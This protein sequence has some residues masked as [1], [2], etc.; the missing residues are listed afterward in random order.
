M[1]TE[2]CLHCIMGC[3]TLLSPNKV[4]HKYSRLFWERAKNKGNNER[5]QIFGCD[6]SGHGLQKIIVGYESFR[7]L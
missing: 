5:R 7:V 4:K 6:E 3:S 2:Y 1:K